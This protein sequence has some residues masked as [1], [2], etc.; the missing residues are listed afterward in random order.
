MFPSLTCF[1]ASDYSFCTPLSKEG[2]S[3]I[4]EVSMKLAERHPQSGKGE[5]KAHLP[6]EGARAAWREWGNGCQS[7]HIQDDDII[8]IIRWDHICVIILAYVHV[9]GLHLG[10]S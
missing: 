10:F 4:W 5:K 3:S 6:T 2:P 1:Y 7:R 8:P 9:R